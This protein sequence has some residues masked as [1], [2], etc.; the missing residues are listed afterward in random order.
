MPDLA[1]RVREAEYSA[2]SAPLEAMAT[3]IAFSTMLQQTGTQAGPA[4][5]TSAP[6]E[7]AMG[8]AS[9]PISIPGKESFSPR[10]PAQ[11][12][13]SQPVLASFPSASSAGAPVSPRL[14][15][16]PA[17]APMLQSLPSMLQRQLL[18]QHLGQQLG[19]SPGSPSQQLTPQQLQLLQ[20]AYLITQQQASMTGT[21]PSDTAPLSPAERLLS[22]QPSLLSHQSSFTSQAAMSARVQ[23]EDMQAYQ[24]LLE[25]QVPVAAAAAAVLQGSG[26][27]MNPALAAMAP[28]LWSH[29]PTSATSAGTPGRRGG[30]RAS[31]TVIACRLDD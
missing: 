23:P 6:T 7:P 10:R 26:R 8:A 18:G 15:M 20:Q 29:G 28:H 25:Q 16:Q 9:Q 3:D 22:Q 24:Q 2:Q 12:L 13:S 5:A 31:I 30:Q 17:T 27:A 14:Q 11:A 1:E 21:S 4:A 19:T